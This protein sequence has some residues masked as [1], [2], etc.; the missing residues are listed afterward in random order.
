MSDIPDQFTIESDQRVSYDTTTAANFTLPLKRAI[1]GVFVLGYANMYYPGYNVNTSNNTI[2]FS[3]PGGTHLATVPPGSYTLATLLTAVATAMNAVSSGYTVSGTSTV[4][5]ANTT[6]VN[7]SLLFNTFAANRTQVAPTYG[8]KPS[9]TMA[10][11]LGFSNA[12]DTPSNVATITGPNVANP[13]WNQHLNITLGSSLTDQINARG[14]NRSFRIPVGN[15]TAGTFFRYESPTDKTLQKTRIDQLE[16]SFGVIVTDDSGTQ[17][18]FQG[19]N[20]S[21][22]MLNPN[23]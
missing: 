1:K 8:L 16:S 6:P 23:V 17:I 22:F 5:I 18:N 11:M 10:S 14:T 15:V 3:D 4:T 20:W 9:S 12:I 21:L 13:F 19:T 7:F 2:S